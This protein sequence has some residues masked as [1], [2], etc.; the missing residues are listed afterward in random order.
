MC[1]IACSVGRFRQFPAECKS[2]WAWGL[3]GLPT[4]CE[5][6]G[7]VYAI[8]NQISQRSFC[9]CGFCRNC[10]CS[11]PIY[12]MKSVVF[13]SSLSGLLA[14][15]QLQLLN[16]STTDFSSTCV[17]VLNQKVS[18]DSV[19]SALGDATGG[20]PVFGTPLFLSFD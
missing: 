14:Q 8:E 15:A 7:A 20:Y 5:P 16:I 17:A 18:C 19:L 1:D 3:M 10:E 9:D 2:P 4:H 12:N 11:E 13:I 6:Q